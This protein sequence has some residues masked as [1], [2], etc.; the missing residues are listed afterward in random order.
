MVFVCDSVM[1]SGKSSAAI[2]YM[3]EHSDKKYVY[4][5]PYLDEAARI[6]AGCPDLR[7]VEPTNKLKQYDH[8]KHLHTASLI[9]EGRNIATTH[10]AFIGY[11]PDMLQRIREQK[12]TL[13]IDENVDVLESVSFHPDDLKLALS[14]GLIKERDG[15][16]SIEDESYN[17]TMLADLYRPM[18]SRQLV[19]MDGKDGDGSLFFWMLPP[20]LLDAFENVFVLTYLFQSQSLHHLMEIYHVPYRYIGVRRYDDGTYRFVEGHPLAYK[21]DYIAHLNEL[22]DI[23]DSERMNDVGDDYYSLSMHWFE[24]NEEGVERLKKNIYNFFNNV[25]RGSP[26]WKRLWGSYKSGQY[27]IRGKGY[28]KVFLPFNTRATNQYGNAEYLVYAANVFMNVGEKQF[29]K[30]HGIEIDEDIYA[31]SVMIQW[32]WRSAIR[33]GEKIHIYIPSRRMRN[34][35]IDWMNK[36]S[37]GG[38]MVG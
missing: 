33:N 18:E 20:D 4:I 32:I 30:A 19:R 23:V 8:R 12:Y 2:T 36:T 21:P 25:W 17:G 6:K 28:S 27:K 9:D 31:L 15:T 34:L 22:I 35:L 26:A 24:S 16:Y 3:N 1:G 29:Y 5:S 11:T 38:E 37:R 14:S 10:R 13:I 7:F